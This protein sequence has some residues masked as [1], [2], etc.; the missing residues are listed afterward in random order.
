MRMSGI[1][2]EN[3][4]HDR[5]ILLAQ[6]LDVVFLAEDKFAEIDDGSAYPRLCNL[7]KMTRNS[8]DDERNKFLFSNQ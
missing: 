3:V 8:F 6:N 1:P 2:Y 5:C 4:D 7:R